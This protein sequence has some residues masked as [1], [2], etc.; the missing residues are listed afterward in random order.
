MGSDGVFEVLEN[1]QVESIVLP[2]YNNNKPETAASSL[3]ERSILQWRKETDGQDDITA[4]V[5]FFDI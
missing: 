5:V 3:V 1:S 4:I 2:Y